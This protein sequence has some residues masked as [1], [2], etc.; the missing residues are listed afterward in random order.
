MPN[1]SNLLIYETH[2][3]AHTRQNVVDDKNRARTSDCTISQIRLYNSKLLPFA[4]LFTRVYTSIL[5]IIR[6]SPLPNP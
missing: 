1:T 3:S 5:V 6:L 2:P 4:K